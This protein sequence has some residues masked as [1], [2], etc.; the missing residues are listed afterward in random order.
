[1]NEI[2]IGFAIDNGGMKGKQSGDPLPGRIEITDAGISIYFDG[3]GVG[4]MEPGHGSI[5]F[6]EYYQGELRVV[7]SPDINEQ[8]VQIISMKGAHEKHRE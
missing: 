2:S 7:L 5:I 4:T 6:I 3:Y 1:M 8:D